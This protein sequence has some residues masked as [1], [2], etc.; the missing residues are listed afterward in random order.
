MR[1]IVLIALSGLIFS[2]CQ[3]AEKVP[4][5]DLLGKYERPLAAGAQPCK[6]PLRPM[7]RCGR[8]L[9]PQSHRSGQG[10]QAIIVLVRQREHQDALPH[11]GHFPRPR[12]SVG[13][14]PAATAPYLTN[15]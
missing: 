10:W 6:G 3:S 13:G 1:H 8:E 11:R 12:Q 5:E 15:R 4:E 7:A 2:G 14:T 9:P